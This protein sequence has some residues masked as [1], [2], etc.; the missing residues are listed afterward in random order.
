[1]SIEQWINFFKECNKREAFCSLQALKAAHIGISLSEAESSVA[2][3]FTSRVANIT[4]VLKLIQEGR[5]ALVTSFGVFKYM[6]LYSLIQFF[7]VLILY[8][9]SQQQWCDNDVS[10]FHVSCGP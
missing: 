5:C 8:R 4:C 10:F 6:A 9:V 3:P 1:M 2:A 7:T